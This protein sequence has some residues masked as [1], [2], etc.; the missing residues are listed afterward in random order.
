MVLGEDLRGSS[1]VARTVGDLSIASRSVG[2]GTG[3]A[4]V[5]GGGVSVVHT[6]GCR[7]WLQVSLWWQGPSAYIPSGRA[8][9]SNDG[10]GR[11]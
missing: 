7:D 4:T 6:H 3:Q 10:Q 2:E 1:V 5:S 8:R 9:T 11:L